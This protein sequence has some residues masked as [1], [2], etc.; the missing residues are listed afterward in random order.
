MTEIIVPK[1]ESFLKIDWDSR[2]IKLLNWQKSGEE[3]WKKKKLDEG[4]AEYV[5]ED[6][7][8][9]S[10]GGFVLAIGGD[11]ERCLGYVEA[12]PWKEPDI[13]WAL[14]KLAN[15]QLRV[16][17]MCPN[18]EVYFVVNL[19]GVTGGFQVSWKVKGVVAMIQNKRFIREWIVLNE[20]KFIL[21]NKD[22][23]WDI[24][25][26]PKTILEMFVKKKFPGKFEMVNSFEEIKWKD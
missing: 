21:F 24:V 4:V 22:G 1:I 23:G 15:L 5:W 11:K 7:R 20:R 25:E 17:E 16:I 26:F 12:I 9:L 19:W 6:K 2:I 13:K 18:K 8:V 10:D 14:E 3:K